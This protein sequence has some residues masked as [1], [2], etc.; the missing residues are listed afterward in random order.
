MIYYLAFF[1][2]SLLRASAKF[3]L[4]L[5][6][7]TAAYTF[8][9]QAYRFIYLFLPSKLLKIKSFHFYPNFFFNFV[10]GHYLIVCLMCTIF[11]YII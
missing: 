5:F 1:N 9:F 3:R 4:N 8:Q 11:Y 6:F 2:K 10:I 7:L